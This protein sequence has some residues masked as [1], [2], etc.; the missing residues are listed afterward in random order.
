MRWVAGE[1][2]SM[3]FEINEEKT[4]IRQEEHLF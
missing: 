1:Y 3:S 4:A 2:N